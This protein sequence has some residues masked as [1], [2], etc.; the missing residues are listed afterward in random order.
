MANS[1][2]VAKN[3]IGGPR[4]PP[5][6]PYLYSLSAPGADTPGGK[7]SRRGRDFSN[8]RSITAHYLVRPWGDGSIEKMKP[9]DLVFFSKTTVKTDKMSTIINWEKLNEILRMSYQISM[10][11]WPS[12][13]ELSFPNSVRTGFLNCDSYKQYLNSKQNSH[14]RPSQQLKNLLSDPSISM[15][16]DPSYISDLQEEYKELQ[17]DELIH[18]EARNLFNQKKDLKGTSG[19]A[20]LTQG[21][22]LAYWNYLGPLQNTDNDVGDQYDPTRKFLI[23]NVVMHKRAKIINRWN[24]DLVQGQRLY[25]ILKRVR[26]DDGTYG[27]FQLT[28]WTSTDNDIRA[29][30]KREDLVYLDISGAPQYG[31]AWFIGSVYEPLSQTRQQLKREIS[32]GIGT[33][34][35]IEAYGAKGELDY[36]VVAA[37]V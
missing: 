9:G 16:V 1:A 28:P 26:H 10:K 35:L 27:E 30:P 12:E 14:R 11:N 3:T 7:P 29:E 8:N 15:Y 18:I 23:V 20:P 25:I 31:K 17:E 33:T 2:Q 13:V 21:G 24:N 19:F 34:S 32:L 37:G 5:G 6:K 4:N 22:I 36:V